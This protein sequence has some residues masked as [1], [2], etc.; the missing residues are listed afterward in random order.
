M[1]TIAEISKLAYSLACN[2]C[3]QQWILRLYNQTWLHHH[4]LCIQVFETPKHLSYVKIFGTY[5]H[6][7]CIHA[8]DQFEIVALSSVNVEKE[9]RLFGYAILIS[10]ACLCCFEKDSSSY[11]R[12]KSG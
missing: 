6:S 4:Q 3:P 8:P 9:E 11:A 10:S 7:L 2:R 5:F 12:K 1:E